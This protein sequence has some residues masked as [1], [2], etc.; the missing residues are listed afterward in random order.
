MSPSSSSSPSPSSPPRLDNS[1]SSL[2]S[3]PSFP[4]TPSR[5]TSQLSLTSTANAHLSPPSTTEISPRR[6]AHSNP[7][8]LSGS[9]SN[10]S[11]PSTPTKSKYVSGNGL[12]NVPYGSLALR[13]RTSSSAATPTVASSSRSLLEGLPGSGSSSGSGL[14]GNIDLKD[15]DGLSINATASGNGSGNTTPASSRKGKEKEKEKGKQ[16][17]GGVEGEM[18]L[19]IGDVRKGLREL[20]RRNTVTA[21]D[22]GHNFKEEIEKN[23]MKDTK[24]DPDPHV[25]DDLT[26][27]GISRYSPR[28][29]YVLTNAGKPVFSSHD[30]SSQ[31]NI[32]ELMAIASTLI[33]I[34][35]E[36]DDKIRCIIKGQTRIGFLLKPPLY[37]FAVSDWGE[38]EHVLR[39]HLEYIHLHILSVVSSTQLSRVF[40]R[41]SNFDLSRLLEGTETFLNKLIDRSQFDF[42][43]LTSTLQPLRMNPATRDMAGAALMPPS[44]FNDLLYVL[45]IADGRI[46]TLL[47][48]RKHA[49]H[50]SDL[51]LLLNTLASSST[52]RSSETWLPICFPK[53]NPAGFVHAYVSYVTEDV[54]LVFV[55]ADREAFEDLRGW[56]SIVMEKLENDKTLSRITESIPLHAYTVSAIGC[57]GLRHFI[58]KS[59]TY[60]QITQPEWEAPYTEDSIDRKRLITLYQKLHDIVHGRSGQTQTYKLVYIRTEHEACLAWLTKPFEL[61]LTVSPQL[62]KFAVVAAANTVAKWVLAEE[63]RV[64]LKDAPVF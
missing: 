4:P 50:P 12:L 29:Y 63:G 43:Y 18:S 61:Y 19:S 16:V 26:K 2:I 52:L 30:N 56:K 47:R 20:V 58:Y 54:G 44:K 64:F 37:L 62:S 45:L 33:S 38:P 10:R 51:H 25:I 27:D 3:P 36:D 48:P 11:A 21:T 17:D 15:I 14:G 8:F 49:V 1:V 7:N 28:K 55:S 6:R 31:D 60:I 42:S 53:F 57:P 23:E 32:T 24:D 34:F 5:T 39:S 59:R 13:S 40:Q 41:R 35:Q 46:V 22:Q 9:G